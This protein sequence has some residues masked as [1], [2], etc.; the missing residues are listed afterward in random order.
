MYYRADKLYNYGYHGRGGKC[1]Y[2]DAQIFGL[3]P[4]ACARVE[5]WM[6]VPW[7]I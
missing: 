5:I 1:N 3:R 6:I 2:A 4:I 7:K